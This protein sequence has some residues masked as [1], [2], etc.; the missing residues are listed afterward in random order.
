MNKLVCLTI[1][2]G[3]ALFASACAKQPPPIKTEKLVQ[4]QKNGPDWIS[5]P[6]PKDSGM[7]PRTSICAA[8]TSNLG[9]SSGNVDMARTDAEMQIK[10]RIAEQLSTEVGL[11]QERVNNVMRDVASGKEVGDLSLKNINK[12]FNKTT[13][14]GLRY[15]A[16][17]MHP[18]NI[19][20]EKVFVLGCVTVDFANMAK[21]IRGSMLGA[22]EVRDVL[23]FK[24][25]ENMLRFDA[26]EQE[27]LKQRDDRLRQNGLLIDT[28][29]Q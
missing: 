29:N 25:Q 22:D 24:H 3:G 23:E 9:L 28:P 17:Y 14:V 6:Y 20:P 13:I 7:D 26:V 27:Y 8:G 16:T 1:L 15:L 21:E 4:K 19:D 5:N 11:L 10:N 12:N 2:A 18:N